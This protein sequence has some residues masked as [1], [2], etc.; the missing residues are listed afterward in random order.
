MQGPQF[1]QAVTESMRILGDATSE[2]DFKMIDNALRTTVSAGSM[3]LPYA[4]TW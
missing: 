1:T 2:L 3:I 4:T